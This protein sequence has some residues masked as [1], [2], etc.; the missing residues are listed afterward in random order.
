MEAGEIH[1]G[2]GY[3]GGESGDEVEGFQFDVCS[4]VPVRCLFFGMRN[5]R[6]N[7]SNND[8]APGGGTAQIF[9]PQQ[10]TDG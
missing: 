6:S 2:Y 7:S 9:A 8:I 3:Q 5:A 4:S 1:L 10:G